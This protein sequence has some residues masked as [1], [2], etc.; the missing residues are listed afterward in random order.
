MVG[1]YRHSLTWVLDNPGLI[2]IVLIL[3]VALNGLIIFKIPNGFFP[4]QDT[5]VIMGGIQGPQDA[6]FP[7]MNFSTVSLVNIVKADPAVAHVNAYTG[8]GNAGFMFIALKP[9][10][11]TCKEGP[12]CAVRQTSAHGRDQPPAAEDE[13]PAHRLGLSA[14]RP[15][16]AHWRPRQQR[17]V[18]IHHP[19]RHHCRPGALGPHPAREYAQTS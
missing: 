17:L 2:L 15:G 8:Q 1:V 4:Q 19:V 9:L 16:S 6:S 12:K 18:S 7:F 11:T 13:P 14:A 10:G 3:T 5:G